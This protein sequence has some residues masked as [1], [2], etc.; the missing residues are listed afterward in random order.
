MEVDLVITPE[1]RPTKPEVTSSTRIFSTAVDGFGRA[2]AI[3]PI[4]AFT[5]A[6][7]TTHSSGAF[8]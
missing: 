3:A 8:H 7:A 1:L 6:E 2:E 5:L 4:L